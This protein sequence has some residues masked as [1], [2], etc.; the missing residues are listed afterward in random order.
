MRRGLRLIIVSLF[1]SSLLFLQIYHHTRYAKSKWMYK[2][3]E[4]DI[5]ALQVMIDQL[6][7]QQATLREPKQ[8]KLAARKLGLVPVSLHQ[9]KTLSH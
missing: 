2:K 8:I 6:H 9:F 5:A 3:N 1:H 4:K 7:M